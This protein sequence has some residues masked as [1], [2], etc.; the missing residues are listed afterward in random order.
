MAPLNQDGLIMKNIGMS[1]EL[2]KKT[3]RLKLATPQFFRSLGVGQG[4]FAHQHRR[5]KGFLK[6]FSLLSAKK[7]ERRPNQ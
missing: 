2:R 7:G 3:M 6:P 4:I 5:D 1:P